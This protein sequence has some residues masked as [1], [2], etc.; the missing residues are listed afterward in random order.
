MFLSNLQ[1]KIG[2]RGSL[3]RQLVRGGVGSA[4]VMVINRLLMLMLA[5]VLSRELGAEG[6]GI[7]VYAL[8][9]MNLLL[10]P[11]GLGMST[12]LVR[13]VAANQ[14]RQEWSYFHGILLRSHQTVFVASIIMVGL[15]MLVLWLLSD[16]IVVN[17]VQTIFFMIVLF[18]LVAL[19][20]TI[21]GALRG[22]Q[23]VVKS[24]SV[25]MLFRPALTLL[26]VG[27]LFTFIPGMRTPQH[28][29]AIQLVA[30]MVVLFIAAVVLYR[31]IPQSVYAATPKYKTGQWL[32]S[33]MPFA[34]IGATGFINSQTDILMLGIFRSQAEVGIYSIATQG[35]ALVAFGLQ[36]ARPLIA[37]Q[38]ARFYAQGGQVHLQKLLKVSGKVIFLVA[39]P[40]A[41]IF[42]IAGGTLAGWVFGAEF[43]QCHM[44]LAILAF[45]Q[46]VNASMGA[47]AVLLNMTGHERD[48]V[49]IM[50]IT[51]GVNVVLNLL[52]IPFFGMEGA[53][54]A[55]AF[56]LILSRIM[57]YRIV[58]NQIG[59]NAMPFTRTVHDSK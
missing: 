17:Q 55:T 35:A 52:L 6:Y 3:R 11:S 36:V 33:A 24:Q 54:C 59:F 5:I 16:K 14:A 28:A 10:I 37:P 34:F 31:Y 30:T 42:I 2:V 1:K 18:P 51:G 47:V 49:R 4:I 19:R 43:A 25:E 23:H 26:G 40:I 32:T 48:V 21:T 57:L 56:S 41:S 22:M 15:A 12:L 44:S 58:R 20:R 46:L 9:L 13:E 7:Y 45:G 53:A 39:L 8:A 50:L 27:I 29:M 38:F